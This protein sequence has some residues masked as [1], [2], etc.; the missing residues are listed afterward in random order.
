MNRS[1]LLI[2][3]MILLAC[4]ASLGLRY[5]FQRR[6]SE[7]VQMSSRISQDLRNPTAP[8]PPEPFGYKTAW[9]A[10]RSKDP[11]AVAS[12][13]ELQNPQPV[14]WQYGVLHAHEYNDYDIFVTPPVN[15]WV[16][17]VGMPIIWEADN[18]ASQR[19]VEL[20]KQF[21][22]S[23][24]FG[25]VRTSDAYLWARASNGKLV[26]LFYEGDGERRVLGDETEAEKTLGFR[27]FDASSP[28]ANQPGYWQRSDLTYPDE[29][30]VLKVAAL[31]SVDPSKVDKMA[32]PPSLGLL[33]SPSA[34]Y[35]PKPAPIHP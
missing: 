32:L 13:L 4:L 30:C 10:V 24:L 31:W 21:H 9:F 26:R 17:A 15:G 7:R 3:L 14:S 19:M 22:E 25:S 8:T 35:P 11:R 18:H 23:Q 2:P 27:F 29:E 33:G 20:S 1:R 34:S 28:E 12:A 5:R 6:P 16:L